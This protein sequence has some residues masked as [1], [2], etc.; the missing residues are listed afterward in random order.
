[1][2]KMLMLFHFLAME[3]LYIIV[4]AKVPF[5]TYKHDDLIYEDIRNIH[6]YAN[7]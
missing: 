1:M 6:N 7:Y 2:V 3:I 5:L 4:T